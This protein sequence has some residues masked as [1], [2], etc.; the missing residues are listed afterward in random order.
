[1]KK[2][3]FKPEIEFI[4]FDTVDVITTSGGMDGVSGQAPDEGYG[5]VTPISGGGTIGQPLQ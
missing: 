2:K 4:K 5:T 1:M 3:M